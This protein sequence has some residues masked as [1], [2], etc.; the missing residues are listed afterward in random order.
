MLFYY[1][2][3]QVNE[4]M[5][6]S[7]LIEQVIYWIQHTK[8]KMKDLNYDHSLYYS[9]KEKHKSLEIKD[10]KTKNILGIQFIT[11]HNYKK[12][13]FTIEILYHY[14]Q[15]ILELSF[16]KEISNES[17]YISKISIPKIFPMILESN[18][19]QK[20]HDLSIQSTPH[21]INERTVNQL[22]KKSYHLPIIILYKNKKCL[23]NPFILNQELYGMCHIIVIPTNKEI[24]YVQ[25]NYPNNEKEKL[26]YEKNFIQTLIQHIRY[27]ML[28]ENEFYS[29]SEL[30]QFEL[31][32][33]YQDDAISSVE[34]QELFLNEIKNIEKDIID[35]QKEYQNKKDI[36]ENYFSDIRVKNILKNSG[37]EKNIVDEEDI[38]GLIDTFADRYCCY[39]QTKKYFPHEMGLFLGYPVEDVEGYLKNNGENSLYTG[40]W[41]VYEDVAAK[42]SL[43]E[44]F[45][46]AKEQIIWFLAQGV[47]IKNLENIA[48]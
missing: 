44:R 26:F 33:S 37:Y 31:L 29:F 34:V 2:K 10:F 42:S 22:L 12:N 39:M 16:Y 24:N 21:F 45:E 38:S 20:D 9:L 3:V 7:L 28:Q 25:I 18:Y 46:K 5:T 27:Y 36:L 41:K 11:D 15:E 48:L 8:N 32:Q 30:Q 4:L 17:K 14:Q 40:Y 6:P 13:Q 35:L 19:I 47:S 43:F 1:T 23:V